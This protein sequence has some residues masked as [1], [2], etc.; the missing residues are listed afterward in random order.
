MW[1]SSNICCVM[2]ISDNYRRISALR[3][4]DSFAT[5][6]VVAKLVWSIGDVVRKERESRRLTQKQLAV[7][8]DVDRTALG[9]LENGGNFE[10]Q[11]LAKLAKALS[12]D[13][14]WRAGVAHPCIFL[15]RG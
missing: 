14:P 13:P 15:W 6:N 3:G 7:K 11:T 1:T 12:P 4:I 2:T 10:Q 8:A 5:T 9:R